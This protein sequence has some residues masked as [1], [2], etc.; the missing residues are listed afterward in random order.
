MVCIHVCTQVYVCMCVCATALMY[1][2]DEDCMV[3]ALFFTWVPGIKVLLSDIYDSSYDLSA[4]LS[5]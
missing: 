3:L 5:C 1:K 4:D 2:S